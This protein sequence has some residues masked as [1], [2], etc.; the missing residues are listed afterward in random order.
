MGTYEFPSD[1]D[2]ATKLVLE[3]IG[4]LGINIINGKGSEIVI[5]PNDFK[6]FCGK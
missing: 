5:T 1:L 6:H 3:E 4:K 2:P